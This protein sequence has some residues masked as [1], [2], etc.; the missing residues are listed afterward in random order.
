M[1]PVLIFARDGQPLTEA[2]RDPPRLRSGAAGTI[3]A[4][5]FC[6]TMGGMDHL[7]MTGIG[8]ATILAVVTLGK[9]PAA[10]PIIAGGRDSA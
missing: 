6:I 9:N 2:L 8:I 5:G 4:I 7:L 3:G 1:S 10:A